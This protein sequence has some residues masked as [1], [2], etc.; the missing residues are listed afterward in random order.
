LARCH[1]H[2]GRIV[3]AHRLFVDL[4]IQQLPPATTPRSFL[5][6]QA[7]AR[8]EL[9]KLRSAV[10][11]I[12]VHITSDL[13]AESLD[14]QIDEVSVSLD[15]LRYMFAVSPGMHA[16]NVKA[17]GRKSVHQPVS[18]PGP[19]PHAVQVDML[20][21]TQ[22]YSAYTLP[23]I[24]IAA[25]GGAGLVVGGITG[26]LAMSEANRFEDECGGSHCPP[27]LQDDVDKAKVLGTVST[28]SFI[29]GGAAALVGIGMAIKGAT[30]SS[31]TESARQQPSFHL[32]VGPGSLLVYGT[33]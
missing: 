16:V 12:Q 18:V 28:T 17:P 10:P 30:Q 5:V 15:K 20:E 7:E 2:L 23:G 26:G 13:P 8:Q 14:V 9:T 25:F 33:F 29:I 11:G 31:G 4:A 24:I 22:D 21:Q 3:Q 6:A 19:G 1:Q 32:G 27:E